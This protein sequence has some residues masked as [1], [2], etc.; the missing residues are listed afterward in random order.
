MI[1]SMVFGILGDKSKEKG[2]IKYVGMLILLLF[3]VGLLLI[4]III[5]IIGFKES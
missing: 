1:A 4:P 5:G 2:S 3:I